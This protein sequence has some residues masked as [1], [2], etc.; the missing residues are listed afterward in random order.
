MTT[1]DRS[2]DLYGL[3][4]SLNRMTRALLLLAFAVGIHRTGHAQGVAIGAGTPTPAASALLDLQSTTQ[5]FLPPRMT[6]AQRTAIASPAAGLLVY[7]SDVNALFQRTN[8]AWSQVGA[9]GGSGWGLTGNAGTAPAT[10][11]LGTTDAQPLVL[12]V[13]NQRAGYVG[14]ADSNIALG[15]LA[16]NAPTTG[17]GNTAVGH[18]TLRNCQSGIQNIG[19]GAFAGFAITSGSQNIAIG[20]AA[21]RT[22]TTQRLLVAIGDSALYWNGQGA[23]SATDAVEN[24]AVGGF[25]LLNNTT[26]NQNTAVGTYALANTTTYSENTALGA[27]ALSG[28]TA[29]SGNVGV[30][31]EAG[32]AVHGGGNTMVGTRASNV[33]GT[34]P[35]H[36]NV[37]I[38]TNTLLVVGSM[39]NNTAVGSFAA[40]SVVNTLTNTTSLGYNAT[41]S[42]DNR[43]TIGTSTNNNLTGG[44]GNWQNLSDG[45]FKSNVREDVPGLDFITRLRPVTY[46]LMAEKVDEHLGIKQRM[47]TLPEA[48]TRA[49]Y[50]NR[51]KEVSAERLTGFIAQEVEQVAMEMGYE[52]DGVHHP[53]N[54]RDHY[55]LG[56]ASFVV[57]LV[58]AVQE[59]QVRIE[60]QERTIAAQQHA[61]ERLENRMN[62]LMN[63]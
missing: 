23:A 44:Y 45:R 11:F 22:A 21:L 51:L 57:P 33:G 1:K 35:S 5:G 60:A 49:W 14:N 47:D 54:E 31:V 20:T 12:R 17:T 43:I 42:A 19:L 3:H 56:Y 63:R 2:I 34:F 28:A 6:T 58:K 27:Y 4:N 41:A 32:N 40:G 8:A 18:N 62:E 25:A 46:T 36:Y 52:F 55:T 48:E 10:N 7:D 30:G 53:L 15:V 16:L 13:A 9:G 61:I 38:G 24:T 29:G 37:A 59:Q 39:N 50:Y 26:G